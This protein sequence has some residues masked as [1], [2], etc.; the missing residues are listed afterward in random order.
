M[1]IVVIKKKVAISGKYLSLAQ[2]GRKPS[3]Q[4]LRL[5]LCKAHTKIWLRNLSRCVK[6]FI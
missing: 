5:Y 4:N 6:V 2:S 3:R 1:E